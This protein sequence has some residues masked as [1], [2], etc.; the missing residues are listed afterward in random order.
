MAGKIELSYLQEC[1]ESKY[2]DNRVVYNL[3]NFPVTNF[4]DIFKHDRIIIPEYQRD[5][6]WD[7]EKKEMLI[8]SLMMNMPIGNIFM[9]ERGFGDYELVDGQHRL[10]AIWS[11]YNNKFKWEGMFYKELPQKFQSRFNMGVVATY[12]TKY[13][14]KKKLIELYY[15]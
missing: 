5:L 3:F 14:D 8:E 12:I 15:R 10:D 11:F 2:G 4:L 13:T 1:V 9:N 7:Q 6:V